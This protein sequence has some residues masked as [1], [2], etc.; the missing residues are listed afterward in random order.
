MEKLQRQDRWE[1]ILKP[2]SEQGTALLTL[3]K[4]L[5]LL[6]C[7][8][9]YILK[10]SSCHKQGETS[11]SSFSRRLCSLHGLAG[12]AE[13]I[14]PYVNATDGLERSTMRKQ[15]GRVKGWWGDRGPTTLFS[16]HVFFFFLRTKT[17][18]VE[19]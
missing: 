18:A 13:T 4:G 3:C 6:S 10:Q 1:T 11:C 19:K 7:T 8:Y 16:F 5:L 15:R 14:N 9:K 2:T 12:F 17:I